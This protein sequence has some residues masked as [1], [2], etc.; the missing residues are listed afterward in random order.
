MPLIR[1]GNLVQDDW[2]QLSD[3]APL[4]ANE[5]V[6]VSVERWQRE[7]ETLGA[8]SAPV[9]VRLRPDQPPSELV[10]D[11]DRFGTVALEFPFFKDGRGFSYARLLRERYGYRGDVRAFGHILQDQYLYLD[12]CGVNVVEVK[13][14]MQ[15]A[16]W[17][18]ALNELSVS[19]QPAADAR[20]VVSN[21]RRESEDDRQENEIYTAEG[22]DSPEQQRAARAARAG[23]LVR[24]FSHAY[25]HL[26]AQKLLAAMIEKE[27]SGS[28]ALVSSFGAEAAVLLHMV[29]RIAP[30]L[31]I[32]FLD[33][34]KI[35]G[36][37]LR[38]R[39]SLINRLSLTD[40]RSV[41]PEPETVAK[42]DPNG[43]LW[44]ENGD[45]CCAM[46]KVEP[47]ERALKGL[48]AWITG[49]K[50][51]QG[52]RRAVLPVIEALGGRV[53]INPLASWTRDL[54]DEYF[55]EHELPHHPLQS[56]GYQSI[57]CMPC[58]D[59]VVDGEDFRA[60]RWRGSDKTECGIHETPAGQSLTSS[61]L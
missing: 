52:Q 26:P 45:A 14:E 16:A 4:E 53:K 27:F 35:F 21:L 8:R 7:R 51:Y 56:E 39:D 36:E 57:G 9:G 23:S 46:R 28:I 49:R 6:I 11:L 33:T 44:Q 34:G 5:A 3:D 2:V 41:Q 19:Y 18:T 15:A 29:S 1:D 13:D 10:D 24:S 50:R 30:S 37:T 60:G 54:L 43:M 25:G 17:S 42:L 40:V 61:G 22:H 31:P 59:R 32:I 12:R 48:D 58:T 47:L 20:Q 55:A 38:Y